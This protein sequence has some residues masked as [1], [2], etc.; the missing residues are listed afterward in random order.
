MS[1]HR[2]FANMSF[3][4]QV[5]ATAS[6]VDYHRVPHW[7]V[8]QVQ[9]R[10]LRG[11]YQATR[12]RLREQQYRLRRL[13][14][15]RTSVR[16]HLHTLS[17]TA[18]STPCGSVPLP[19]LSLSELSMANEPSGDDSSGSPMGAHACSHHGNLSGACSRGLFV[20]HGMTALPAF[21]IYR[22]HKRFKQLGQSCKTWR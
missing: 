5:I 11:K 15:E 19:E 13:R 10:E 22:M 8:L 4:L 16:H 3:C 17:A 1:K 20:S 2:T 14:G 6:G 21:F 12:D 9:I 7:H 18:P